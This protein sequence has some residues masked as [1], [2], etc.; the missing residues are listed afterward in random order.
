ME[1]WHRLG[2]VTAILLAGIFVTTMLE[3]SRGDSADSVPTP[4]FIAA[5]LEDQA[6][7]YG[8]SLDVS[9]SY[10]PDTAS[11]VQ[12]PSR[13]IKTPDIVYA[14]RVHENGRL[15][16]DSYNRLTAEYHALAVWPSGKAEGA[17]GSLAQGLLT[18]QSIPDPVHYPLWED[19]LLSLIARGTV[20]PRPESVG[21]SMCWRVSLPSLGESLT[22]WVDPTIGFC[23]RRIEA[24]WRDVPTAQSI[25]FRSYQEISPGVWYPME[26]RSRLINRRGEEIEVA[27][28]VTSVKI[29]QVFSPSDLIVTFP[30][31]TTVAD[32]DTM[33]EFVQP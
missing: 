18:D 23:P 3:S 27:S 30:S 5:A 6:Y 32:N 29:G 17:V 31:G 25:E 8:G 28:R 9:F 20:S 26:L 10:S 24:K 21:G 16:R 2:T 13:Y 7:A 12:R 19:S 1:Q 14:E 22:V 33:T 11:A 15:T 4:G